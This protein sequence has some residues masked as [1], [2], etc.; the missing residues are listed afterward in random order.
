MWRT[1]L[2]L[3]SKTLLKEEGWKG[4][5]IATALKRSGVPSWVF[6]FLSFYYF[7]TP[8]FAVLPFM[9]GQLIFMSAVATW[10]DRLVVFLTER[11]WSCNR[12]SVEG[13]FSRATSFFFFPLATT[14]SFH[15]A[16]RNRKGARNRTAYAISKCSCE[17]RFELLP[18]RLLSKSVHSVVSLMVDLL[19]LKVMVMY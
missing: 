7:F 14:Q 16:R 13:D 11:I 2:C 12:C 4:I 5:C 1:G 19:P 17:L 9:K 10:W 18:V 8:F 3:W 15:V 6:T